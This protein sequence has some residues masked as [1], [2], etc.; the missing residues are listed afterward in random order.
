MRGPTSSRTIHTW[1]S[2]AIRAVCSIRVGAADVVRVARRRRLRLR[3]KHRVQLGLSLY[4]HGRTCCVARATCAALATWCA[5][6]SP[7]AI[8]GWLAA[9]ELAILDGRAILAI[10]ELTSC[11]QP[12]DVAERARVALAHAF[13]L[14]ALGDGERA[15]VAK[16]HAFDDAAPLEAL[17]RSGRIAVPLCAW[18]LCANGLSRLLKALVEQASTESAFGTAPA[19]LFWR[20]LG[21]A[22]CSLPM[23]TAALAAQW[24]ELYKRI[25]SG[26]PVVSAQAGVEADALCIVTTWV[27]EALREEAEA[28]TQISLPEGIVH[29]IE[30]FVRIR[31]ER[32]CGREPDAFS[33]AVAL[34]WE[35]ARA[36]GLLRAGSPLDTPTLMHV[37]AY[38]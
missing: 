19:L 6:A 12:A 35:R 20:A 18:G 11:A 25:A 3:P 23:G 16:R 38:E 34:S 7:P 31:T 37:R 8:A 32:F 2:N 15:A 17:S 24:A 28:T 14:V 22:A 26:A 5:S 10:Q 21:Q 9:W 29:D 4:S 27:I 30:R 36:D 13:S 33:L 1:E